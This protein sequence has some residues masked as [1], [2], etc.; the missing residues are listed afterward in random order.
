MV[1]KG[2]DGG[3]TRGRDQDAHPHLGEEATG[4]DAQGRGLAPAAIGNDHQGPPGAA[5]GRAE[6]RCYR[7]RL[8]QGAAHRKGVGTLFSGNKKGVRGK[9]RWMALILVATRKGVSRKGVSTLFSGNNKG[10]RGN[11]G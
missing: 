10:V 2:L 3:P 7:L 11:G 5:M 1:E 8:I 4:R 9:G 6:D